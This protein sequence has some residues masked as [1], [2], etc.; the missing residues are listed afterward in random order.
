MLDAKRFKATSFCIV[1]NLTPTQWSTIQNCAAHGHE[2]SSHTLSYPDL[3]KSSQSQLIDEELNSKN[4]IQ[5]HT[6]HNCVSLAYPYCTVPSES[7]T[8][9]Y[10]TFVR[11][12]NGS[13]V[14]SSPSDM[15]AIGALGPDSTVVSTA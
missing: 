1:G 4:L 5:S 14:S 6:G 10:Y 2:V 12:C 15:L 7:T 8:S 3:T 13:L 9:Q 11:S